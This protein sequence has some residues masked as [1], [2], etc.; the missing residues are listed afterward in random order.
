MQ[1]AS[2]KL[3]DGCFEHYECVENYLC[4]PSKDR[5]DYKV[6]S[7]SNT[8]KCLEINT[9]KTFDGG[10]AI[11][12]TSYEEYIERMRREEH[13]RQMG[14]VL[15]NKESEPVTAGGYAKRYPYAPYRNHTKYTEEDD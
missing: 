11:K 13:L 15:H 4:C 3:D 5:L 10:E 8:G 7:V 9:D 14:L 2:K 1:S 12:Y 6:C